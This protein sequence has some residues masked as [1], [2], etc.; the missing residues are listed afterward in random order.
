ML[1]AT[2]RLHLQA[3]ETAEDEVYFVFDRRQLFDLRVPHPVQ[4]SI[5]LAPDIESIFAVHQ[6]E[7]TSTSVFPQDRTK[8]VNLEIAS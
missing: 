2:H 4:R 7:P 5:A 1:A 8:T 6:N 3:T